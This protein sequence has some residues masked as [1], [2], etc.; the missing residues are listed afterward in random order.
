MEENHDEMHGMNQGNGNLCPKV[1]ALTCTLSTCVD[2]KRVKADVLA[3]GAQ[4]LLKPRPR[5]GVPYE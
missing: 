3:Q 5:V 1:P 4:R 2:S